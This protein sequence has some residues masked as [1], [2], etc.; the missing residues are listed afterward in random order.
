LI[1]IMK[2]SIYIRYIVSRNVRMFKQSGSRIGSGMQLSSRICPID[3]PAR[4]FHNSAHF[5]NGAWLF[6]C[7]S[8]EIVLGTWETLH[9]G[10]INHS[11]WELLDCYS[12]YAQPCRG[13][14]VNVIKFT[15]NIKNIGNYMF[16]SNFYFS[17]F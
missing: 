6:V 10:V 8:H 11:V 13:I 14:N 15:D 16:V 9:N 12:N 7:R 5:R 1:G 3:L 2:I 17:I 4:I